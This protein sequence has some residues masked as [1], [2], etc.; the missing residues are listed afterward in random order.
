MDYIYE[1]HKITNIGYRKFDFIKSGKTAVEISIS[2]LIIS[3]LLKSGFYIKTDNNIFEWVKS[4]NTC[5]DNICRECFK[6]KLVIE[7]TPVVL[8][9]E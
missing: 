8:L 6:D 7:K 9:R 1:K 5:S 4:I 2:C 3:Y